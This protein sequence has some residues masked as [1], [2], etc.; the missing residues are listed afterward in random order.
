[1]KKNNAILAGV[2]AVA[3]AAAMVPAAMA[4]AAIEGT[5]TQPTTGQAV[6]KYKVTEGYTWSIHSDID[7][8][9]N[10]GANST[11]VE[12]KSEANTVSVSKNVIAPGNHLV[13]TVRG[14]GADSAFTI[15]NK[16]SAETT[17]GYAVSKKDATSPLAVNG[18][19]LSLEAGMNVGSQILD[20][21]LTTGS[22][23]A[24]VAGE[25]EGHVVYTAA[26]K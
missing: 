4:A 22:G 2:A 3:L 19:V 25:Y 9:A 11:K 16:T 17:L 15:A 1:M 26:V 13:I 18:E 8:G 5:S 7:F 14:D 12:V 21:T 20:F 23:T 24:E 6:V 10:K